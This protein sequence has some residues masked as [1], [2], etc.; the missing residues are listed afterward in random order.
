MRNLFYSQD[1]IGRS[2]DWSRLLVKDIIKCFMCAV[3]GQE[4]TFNSYDELQ[5]HLYRDH[6]MRKDEAMEIF[7]K[8]KDPDRPAEA[9]A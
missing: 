4:R 5:D 3:K 1:L 8:Y 9:P 2:F 6:D 7:N